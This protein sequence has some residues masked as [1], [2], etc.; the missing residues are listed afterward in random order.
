M[1]LGTITDPFS[2]SEALTTDL[3]R[4]S[5]TLWLRGGIYTIGNGKGTLD[6]LLKGTSSKPITIRAYP[7]ESVRINGGLTFLANNCQFVILRNVE[8]ASTPTTRTFATKAD[9]DFPL[10]AYFTGVGNKLINCIIHDCQEGCAWFGSGVGEI[11]GCLFYNNGWNVDGERDYAI[12]S[13]NNAG[14]R[15]DLKHNIFCKQ[16]G[17]YGFH[18]FSTGNRVKDYYIDSNVFLQSSQIFE[19]GVEASNLHFTNNCIF[20]GISRGGGGELTTNQDLEMTGNYYDCSIIEPAG[21]LYFANTTFTGNT[22]VRRNITGYQ[23]AAL[24][25]SEGAVTTWNNNTYYHNLP[26]HLHPFELNAVEYFFA[27]WQGLGFDADSTY[28]RDLPTSNVVFV[29]A[30]NYTDAYDPRAGIVAIY[31]HQQLDTVSVDLSALSLTVGTQ[32]RLMQAQDPYIDAVT[33]TYNGNLSIDMRAASHS[34]AVPTA[35]NAALAGT[36]FPTFGCFVVEKA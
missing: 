29:F 20:N 4:S 9:I 26:A 18:G 25:T 23:C 13:H 3:I 17:N 33:F 12:Y 14:G 30:N 28:T 8:I 15:R 10:G 22:I 21:I 6:C 5:D 27:D 34:V 1:T 32:Y 7:G 11:Y 24:K 19:S 16:F 36:T 31:N 2:L 35:Y